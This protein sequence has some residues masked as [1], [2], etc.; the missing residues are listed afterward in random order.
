MRSD[1]SARNWKLRPDNQSAI[2]LVMNEEDVEERLEELQEQ[3]DAYRKRIETLEEELKIVVR[4]GNF[5]THVRQYAAGKGAHTAWAKPP[6]PEDEA[7][8]RE[9]CRKFAEKHSEFE[10]AGG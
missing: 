9:W 1:Y 5:V 10:V 3:V 8:F 2:V 6:T 7:I 4:F